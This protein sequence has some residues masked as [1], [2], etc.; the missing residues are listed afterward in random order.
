MSSKGILVAG[1]ASIIRARPTNPPPNPNPKRNPNPNLRR[2]GWLHFWWQPE[3]R[4]CP[5]G[6]LL[7]GHE[8]LGERIGG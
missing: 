5:Y 8:A 7:G 6:H 4:Y 2:H 3:V 1:I